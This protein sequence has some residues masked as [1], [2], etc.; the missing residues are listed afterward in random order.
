[1]DVYT[2]QGK[3]TLSEFYTY[4]LDMLLNATPE[5]L[6]PFYNGFKI[7]S[8]M[9]GNNPYL[10][11]TSRLYELLL[12]FALNNILSPEDS[13][14]VLDNSFPLVLAIRK[15]E[16]KNEI[17]KYIK[18]ENNNNWYSFAFRLALS[19]QK[20]V[21]NSDEQ[22]QNL[23]QLIIIKRSVLSVIKEA[24][25][26]ENVPTQP[27]NTIQP[28]QP[29]PSNRNSMISNE[30]LPPFLQ[31]NNAINQSGTHLPDINK[32][33]NP[34][35]NMPNDVIKS[36]R[37]QITNEMQILLGTNMPT[38]VTPN[39]LQYMFNLYDKLFF[40]GLI[41]SNIQKIGFELSFDTS[42]RMTS[43]AGVC[44]TRGKKCSITISIPVIFN[45]FKS[46]E[47]EIDDSGV[48]VHNRL[49]VLQITFEH[50]LIHLLIQTEPNKII[51]P[52]RRKGFKLPTS[53]DVK[54]II[55]SYNDAHNMYSPHGT[56]FK[57]LVFAFFGQTKMTHN[58]LEEDEDEI[59][60]KEDKAN[61][62]YSQY[63]LNNLVQNGSQVNNNLQQNQVNNNLQQNQVNNNLQQNQVNNLMQSF[64]TMNITPLLNHNQQTNNQPQQQTNPF[65]FQQPQ[66]IQPQ[67]IQPQF[68]QQT[69][70][71]DNKSKYKKGMN[72]MFIYDRKDGSNPVRT[73]QIERINDKTL[74][75]VVNGSR[76]RIPYGDK[77]LRIVN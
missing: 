64:Q 55:M 62:I 33:P 50:E 43:T 13:Q 68:Q 19:V 26:L 12:I 75:I 30:S 58:L 3:V 16:L 57:A 47:K 20:L 56:Y 54:G 17:N 35:G 51:V 22:N 8:A 36:L 61:A 69:P 23:R 2:S 46:G 45:T 67:Q 76:W 1:M 49:E 34:I 24:K 10:T 38:S 44:K 15:D 27:T 28:T 71:Q 9:Y 74:S 48:P 42:S 29:T 11:S 77:S 65:I 59:K 7:S 4:S 21:N 18:L 40:H 6:E 32:F 53:I 52:R 63:G 5:E 39:Q 37:S 41:S 73:G 60:E 72:V 25:H 31:Y 14:L 70:L 66:Q